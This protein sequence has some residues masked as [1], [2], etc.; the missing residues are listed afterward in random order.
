L[1]TSPDVWSARRLKLNRN[2]TW[3]LQ[4]LPIPEC[5]WEVVIM[6]FIMGLPR[7]GNY[8]DSIMVVVDKI[9]KSSHFIPIK[10]IKKAAD[11]AD[12]FMREVTR[13][14]G[15]PKTIVS[16]RDPKLTSNLWKGLVKGFT[17]NLNFS[18]TYHLESDG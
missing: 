4:P 1:N 8:H 16:D 14:N 6:D 17:M 9:M 11:V 12:I 5:K 7:T 15:I 10:N 3:L 13:L 2:P 18:K